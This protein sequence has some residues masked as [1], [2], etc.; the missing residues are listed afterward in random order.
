LR[1]S[2]RRKL[3]Y[4][5]LDAYPNG[6]TDER[7]EGVDVLLLTLYLDADVRGA[8]LNAMKSAPEAG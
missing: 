1:G 5:L 3:R 7:L 8:F 4:K 2:L 6:H